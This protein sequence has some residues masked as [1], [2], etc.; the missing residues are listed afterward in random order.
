MMWRAKVPIL[1]SIV[2]LIARS[3][4]NK[5]LPELDE[6]DRLTHPEE[7]AQEVLNS[8]TGI[9]KEHLRE[10]VNSSGVFY[11][12]KSTAKLPQYMIDLYNRYADDRTSMPLSN[13]IRSFIVEDIL[14][15]SS[16]ENLLQSHIL[17]FN[18]TIPPHE[19]VTKAELNLKLSFG[20]SGLGHLSLFDVIHIEPSDNLRD[21]DSFLA[22]KD[23]KGDESV[24]I[25]VTKAVKRWMESKEHLNKLEIFL[26]M[27]K[28]L[29]TCLKTERFALDSDNSHSPILVI[30][31]DD[32]NENN[33]KEKPMDLTQMM[34]YERRNNLRIFSQNTTAGHGEGHIP[35]ERGTRTKRSVEKNYCSKVSLMVNF[36]D[37]GWN[38]FI[39][40]PPSYD[41]GQC[42]GD[43]HYPLTDNLTPTTYAIVK[44]LLQNNRQKGVG[45]VCCVPT[46]LEGL[47]VVYRESS[48]SV[49]V[50]NYQDMKVVECG[51]R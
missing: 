24:T 34:L 22:S 41:A 25:D 45:N 39:I 37:I 5:P 12:E 3:T 43:C 23:V 10:S 40:F 31:S 4:L 29:E 6:V 8:L 38:T 14:S 46:K 7:E 47:Q 30:F 28:P 16:Q 19:E 27:K 35:L 49:Y 1:C 9:M 15:S 2:I 13:I 50:K 33:M 11:Q 36:K 21:P 17:L 32:Q 20:D 26:K 44:S 42:V 51:C 18:V 48:K